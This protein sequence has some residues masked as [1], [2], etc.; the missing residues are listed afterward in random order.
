[1]NWCVNSDVDWC[2]HA[3]RTFLIAVLSKAGECCRCCVVLAL[4]IDPQSW[5]IINVVQ[6]HGVNTDGVRTVFNIHFAS[7]LPG[8]VTS[9]CCL[10]A[11]SAFHSK[12]FDLRKIRS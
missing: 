2:L 5:L 1:M 3:S 12:S 6:W 4:R 10:S 9:G 8:G 7:G 11:A